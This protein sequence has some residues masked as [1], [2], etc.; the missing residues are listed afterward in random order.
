MKMIIFDDQSSFMKILKKNKQDLDKAK[1]T[2]L[3][4]YT[5]E[6]REIVLGLLTNY[7]FR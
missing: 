3:R 7:M 2:R 6:L 5:S 4:L 1:V